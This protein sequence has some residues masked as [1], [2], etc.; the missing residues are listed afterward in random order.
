MVVVVVVVVAQVSVFSKVACTEAMRLAGPIYAQQLA[1]GRASHG[2]IAVEPAIQLGSSALLPAVDLL[3][4]LRQILFDVLLASLKIV[5][6]GLQQC[7]TFLLPNLPRCGVE[8]AFRPLLQHA[9][10]STFLHSV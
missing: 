5:I 10:C 7:G 2:R 8:P 4:A 1:D 6:V 9:A 3:A